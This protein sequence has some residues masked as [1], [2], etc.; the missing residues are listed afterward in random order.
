MAGEAA[1]LLV[2]FGRR[3]AAAVRLA[4]LVPI[5]GIA[6]FRA[7]AGN[8]PAT[9]AV[10][11]V[12]AAWTCGYAWWMR[13]GRGNA[14]IALDVLVLLGLCA[15]V[16]LT[17]AVGDRNT[18]WLRLLITFACVT[19]QWHTPPFVGGIAAVAAGGGAAALFIAA[20]AERADSSLVSGVLWAIPAA[21]LSR[22]AWVLV[23]HAAERADRMAAEAVRARGESL[24]A[25]AVRAEERELANSL[26]D[27]AA[28]TLLM[29]GTGQVRSDAGWLA[30]Q[31][32]RDLDRLR[33]DGG[34]AGGEADLVDRLR[35][36]LGTTQL[37]V[38]FDAPPRLPLPY[39]V[40]T[41]LAD[42]AGEA[43]TN[44]RRHAGTTR[45]TV[46]LRGDARALRLDIADR[47]KGFSPSDVP[48]TRRGI[49]ESLRGRMD[50]IGGTAT[51]TTAEGEGTLVRLEWRAD[52]AADG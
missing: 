41:A 34:R 8:L 35:A 30:P 52:G 27:T 15:S 43:L 7:S 37:A 23:H 20:G 28:T 40:A 21:A 18:G 38:E 39:D 33:S 5:C 31:A 51:I 25:E 29:V 6:L 3:Y 24:V 44:V 19:F 13:A 1:L 2:R 49:R 12:A 46:R 17:D 36:D 14:P 26:H 32:R 48:F 11:A 10:V 47:G 16:F 42:A 22:V 50:R 45:A 4:T 9:A